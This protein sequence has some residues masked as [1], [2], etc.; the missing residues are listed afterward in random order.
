MKPTAQEDTSY[1]PTGSDAAYYPPGMADPR[2]IIEDRAREHGGLG[3]LSRKL[4]LNHAYLQQFVKRGVPHSLPEHVRIPLAQ[5]IGVPEDDLRG[6][7][8]R[9]QAMNVNE[10]RRPA[11]NAIIGTRTQL[12]ATIPVYGQAVGGDDGRFILNGNKIADILAPPA[13]AGVR[14]AYAVYVVGDSMSPRYEAGEAVYVNPRLPIR[15][16]DYVVVQ[17]AG[18]EGES[19][20]AYVKRFRGRDA[21]FLHLEQ[22]HPAKRMDFPSKKVVSVHRIVLGGEG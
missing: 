18:N 8:P 7:R 16:G 2:K 4:G 22:L 15:R 11:E 12:A 20:S 17:I 6:E 21:R 10:I 14:D 9:R 1:S 19:P 3:P 13:L 5:A